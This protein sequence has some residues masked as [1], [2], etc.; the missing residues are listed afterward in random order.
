[1][2]RSSLINRIKQLNHDNKINFGNIIFFIAII[3]EIL[4]VIIDKS[5]LINPFEGRL[6]QLTFL[7][8]ALKIIATKYNINEWLLMLSFLI[9][10]IVVDQITEHNEVIRFVAFIAASKDIDQKKLLKVVL[11]GTTVGM[12]MLVLLSITGVLGDVYLVEDFYRKVGIEKRYCLGLGHPN[13]LHC[14]FW[15]LVTLGVCVYY[16]SLK[17]YQYL[18]LIVFNVGIFVLTNSRTGMLSTMITIVMGLICHH[19][20][21]IK[22]STWVYIGGIFIILSGVAFSVYVAC[23]NGVP[24]E[25]YVQ[26]TPVLKKIDSMT[27]GRILDGGNVGNISKWRLFSDSRVKGYIDMG[28]I[29][30]FYWYGIVPGILYIYSIIK[31]IIYSMKKQDVAKLILIVSFSIY[32]IIEAHT[33]SP[34]FARNYLLMLFFGVWSEVF[35]VNKSTEGFFWQVKKLLGKDNV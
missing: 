24:G 6:F 34:Y 17:S 28:Y 19:I 20:K 21:R 10:G 5:S 12:L 1:M 3:I 2:G 25:A 14:M 4:I 29:K 32:T 31:L 23:F 7:L 13:A 30:L 26:L 16:D 22:S 9:I 33:I 15:A 11:W 18:I 27:T 35:F 8:C